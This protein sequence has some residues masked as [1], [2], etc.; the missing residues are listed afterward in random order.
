M[1]IAMVENERIQVAAQ[2]TAV[3]TAL[4][5]SSGMS[6]DKCLE[7]LDITREVAIAAGVTEVIIERFDE[8]GAW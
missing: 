4:A 6:L 2:L 1:N 5:W 7:D 8:E 3:Y